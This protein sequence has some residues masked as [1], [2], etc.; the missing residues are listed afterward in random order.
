MNQVGV[1][2]A[3]VDIVEIDT[4]I[5]ELDENSMGSWL[6]SGK[7]ES[8]L[9]GKVDLNQYDHVFCIISLNDLH[10]SYLG[11]DRRR[12]FERHRP[13]MCQSQKL[14]LLFGCSAFH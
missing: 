14:G 8:L 7:A 13:Y 5:T 9:K 4:A 11:A 1:M 6:S 3:H 2:R 10:T 12:I